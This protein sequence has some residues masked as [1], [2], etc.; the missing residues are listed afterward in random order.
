M[1]NFSFTHLPLCVATAIKN[2]CTTLVASIDKMP[3]KRLK[4]TLLS[5]VPEW[6]MNGPALP[7]YLVV[8]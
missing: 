6:D 3:S 7:T 1:A 5:P 4:D 8:L 2:L